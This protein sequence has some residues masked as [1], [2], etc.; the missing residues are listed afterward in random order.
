MYS[1]MS[2]R[3]SHHSGMHLTLSVLIAADTVPALVFTCRSLTSSSSSFC[4]S[5]SITTFSSYAFFVP[6]LSL[7]ALILALITSD[8]ALQRR[9]LEELGS[10]KR[11]LA[12]NELSFCLERQHEYGEMEEHEAQNWVRAMPWCRMD[13]KN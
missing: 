10:P 1:A 8:L 12:S 6:Y 4:P 9:G 11:R 13:G 3:W 5:L 7:H 2:A